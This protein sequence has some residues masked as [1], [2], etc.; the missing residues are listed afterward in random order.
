M[1]AHPT[2]RLRT[3]WI[4]VSIVALLAAVDRAVAARLELAVLVAPV[5]RHEPAVVAFLVRVVEAV[6]ADRRHLARRRHT[7]Q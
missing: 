3:V 5:A 2:R 4:A 7:E 6:A 1:R